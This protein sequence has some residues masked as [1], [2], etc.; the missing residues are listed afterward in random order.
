MSPHSWLVFSLW[1]QQQQQQVRWLEEVDEEER[2][3]RSKEEAVLGVWQWQRGR[4]L[5]QVEMVVALRWRVQ[6]A[7]A[8]LDVQ[9]CWRA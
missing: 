2:E 8:A 3:R 5:L 4:G 1:R 6:P 7:L 9:K